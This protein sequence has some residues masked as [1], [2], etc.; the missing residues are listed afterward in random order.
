L[1][2]RFG[3]SVL[4]MAFVSGAMAWIGCSSDAA[5]ATPADPAPNDGGPTDGSATTKLDVDSGTTASLEPYRIVGRFDA[6]DPA[7]PR[8]GWPGTQIIA[9]FS[10]SSISVDL[11]DTTEEDQFDVGIDD[12]PVTLLEVD[13]KDKKTYDLG[14]GLSPGIHTL[15]LTKRTESSVGETQLLKINAT[16]VGTPP[17]AARRIEMIG[18]SITAG[19]GVL[20]ADSSCSFSPETEDE[21]LAWGA[22]AAKEL[23]AVHTAIAWSGI[24]LV[25][26]YEGETTDEM[27]DRY[28]RALATDAAS[29]WTPTLFEPDVVVIALGTNDFSGEGDDPGDA[30]QT[31][32]VEFLTTI[33]AAHANSQIVLATSPMLEGQNKADQEKYFQGAIDARKAADPKISLLKI[34]TITEAEGF[35]CDYH[36]SKATQTRMATALV[37]HVKTLTGW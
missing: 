9:K 11:A 28:A 23:D 33:R 27:P 16:L 31:K 32:L 29:T 17:P 7:G 4:A 25:Q 22:L 36:P 3:S 2:V 37:A 1:F 12:A 6:R 26:N 8:F 19:Y 13:Q 21:S 5:T 10:G 18:D 15:T 14:T 20:G 34:D 30:F 35:G 24:G